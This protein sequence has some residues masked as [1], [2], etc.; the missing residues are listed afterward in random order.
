MTFK[1]KTTS[2]RLT[3]TMVGACSVAAMSLG[4]SAYALAQSSSSPSTLP[5]VNVD[6][7]K[8]APKKAQPAKKSATSSSGKK[9]AAPKQK[10]APSTPVEDVPMV[11]PEPA[12][13]V[14]TARTGAAR[15]A[16]MQ[17]QVYST[18]AAVSSVGSAELATYGPVDMGDVLRSIPGTS[19][20]ESPAN[21]GVGVNI[22]GFE[23]SGRVNMMI[24]GVRQNFRFT[25]HEAQG[26]TYVDPAL[27]AGVDIARGAV[28]TVG[29]GGALAG[30]ANFRTIDIIDVLKPG[31]TVGAMTALSYGT[32]GQNWN[33]MLSGAMSNGYVGFVGAISGHAPDDFE[34]GNGQIVPYT[35]Q[36]KRSG[37]LKGEFRL[38]NEHKVKVGGIFYNNDFI[39]NSYKQRLSSDI[40]TFNYHYNPVGTELINLKIN[41]SRSDVSMIYFSPVGLPIFVVP[42]TGRYVNDLGTGF[43]ITNVSRLHFGGLKIRSEYGFEY[44][45]DDVTSINSTA[46]PNRGVNPSGDSS[47]SSA[48]SST[49]FSYGIF[50]LITGLRYDRFSLEGHGSTTA[51][52]PL[53]MPVGPYTVDR[54]EGRFNPKITL[55]A[56]LSPWFQPYVTY[57]ESMRA[58]TVNE[59]LMGGEHP[60][61]T[62]GQSFFPNPFL[63]PEVQKGWEFGFNTSVERLFTHRDILRFKADYF[64]QEIDNYIIG[65]Q[66]PGGAGFFQY[67]TNVP[68]VSDVQGVELQGMYDSGLFFA[69]LSYTWTDTNLPPQQ[70][71][72][73]GYSFLPDHVV[74]LSGGV[75]LLDERWTLGARLFHAS[76][77]FIGANNTAQV[78]IAV[79][80]HT[81]GY[82][83]VD[84]YTSY[85]L[86]PDI[87]IGATMTNVFDVGFTPATSTTTTGGFAG[88]TG[89]GRTT[90]FTARA[91][92]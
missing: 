71:G 55:A 68:G 47:I 82:T 66:R 6:P 32:N 22:R 73:G 72:L 30:T 70:N 75:R 27:I 23:G 49:T 37:L 10:S 60:G 51:P 74:T 58:P 12:E 92:F 90:L 48:F 91:R 5:Q 25:G 42:A 59:T 38:N 33:K 31:Q 84:L 40:Y 54:D 35:G 2:V 24:D 21:P 34:N 76:D 87:E 57:S 17:T 62:P 86:T 43:D 80:D 29:G 79:G 18:P 46:V 52:N 88:E 67:F 26:F 4:F 20:R 28:S 77:A 19:V 50:D 53:D 44:F 11:E 65:V 1:N 64:R 69:G 3:H 36:D 13:T 56:T 39:S 8:A 7:P 41:A 15:D 9:A 89:R 61:A 45:S 85:K 81:K 63:E 83:L 78:P 14:D 16:A